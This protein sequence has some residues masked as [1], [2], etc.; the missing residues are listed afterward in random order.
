[1]SRIFFLIVV[2]CI[3]SDVFDNFKMHRR[4]SWIQVKD[5]VMKGEPLINIEYIFVHETCVLL[6]E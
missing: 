1:M 3:H 4:S 2:K 5:I 6:N